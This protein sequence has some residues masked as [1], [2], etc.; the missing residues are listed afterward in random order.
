MKNINVG[1]RSGERSQSI[2]TEVREG[3]DC[4]EESNFNASTRG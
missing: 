3:E 2:A 4:Q 1:D